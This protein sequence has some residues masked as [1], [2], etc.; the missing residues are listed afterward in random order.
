MNSR[1]VVIT[2][3]GVVS[4]LGVGV[5][6]AWTNLINGKSGIV[7]LDK[8]ILANH[9]DVPCR[10]GGKVPEGSSSD[11]KWD[12]LEWIDSKGTLRRIPTFAQY[13]LAATKQA[14]DDA[15]WHPDSDADRNSTGVCVGSG[16]GGFEDVYSNVTAFN[17]GGYRKVAP[18]FIPRLLSNMAAGHISIT[19]HLRGPNSAPATACTTGAH[20]IGDAAN[21][22]L[23]GMADV[24]VAGS[25]EA[26][27]HPV[28]L[29]GFSRA[30]SV[31]T[32]FNDTPELA[33]RPFDKGRGGFVMGEG[34]GIFILEELEHALAR[35][36]PT[37]YGEVVGYGMSGDGHHIT[38]PSETGDGA[39]RSMQMAIKRAGIK[40]SQVDYVNAHATSTKLGDVA[41]NRAI[42]EV[43][44][45]SSE[46]SSSSDQKQQEEEGYY[47]SQTK[48]I[49]ISS[50]K[51]SMGHLLGGAGSVEA[52]F[53]L[54]ALHDNI[55]P[56]TLNLT[57]PD[58]GFDCNYVPLVAQKNPSKSLEY[59]MSNSFG[60]G[61]TNATLLLKKWTN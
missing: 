37:I 24:M 31:A 14:L 54:M 40:P 46:E 43:L 35:G 52:L 61:G 26:S 57:D 17:S 20:A 34:S 45:G 38:A 48:E 25:S 11:G 8:T 30:K 7:S 55:L 39:R 49:N 9:P 6:T 56:P 2:G 4:P 15:N 13:A 44:T 33:S 3:L 28:A 29:A 21:M 51:G 12:P 18:L 27:L 22:I 36:A 60:F 58:E 50:T 16:I 41:E 32:G 19:H 23:L 53:T 5:K 59:A 10:I 47:K 42:C 1:R